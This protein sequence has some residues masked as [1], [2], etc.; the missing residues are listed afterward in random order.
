LENL[1]KETSVSWESLERKFDRGPFSAMFAVGFIVFV[2]V[3]A[4]GGCSFVMNPLRQAGRVVNKTIDAD[5]MIYNYEWFKLRHESINA[6]DNK[7]AGA[8]MSVES[9]SEEL[10]ERKN[11]DWA[12]KEEYARLQSILLGLKQQKSDLAGEYNAKSR[13]VNRK[14][15]KMGDV[16]LPER[17]KL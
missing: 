4:I 9:F 3:V 14:I 5:N 10:G 16:E 12:D 11:W 6:L 1:K 7:I 8:K 15:F 17:I 2:G 13:M